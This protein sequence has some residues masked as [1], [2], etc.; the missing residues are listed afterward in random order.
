M[1]LK[2]A[3]IVQHQMFPE[4][5]QRFQPQFSRSGSDARCREGQFFL[6]AQ[7]RTPKM[8][9][10]P[11]NRGWTVAGGALGVPVGIGVL[12]N[13]FGIFTNAIGKEFGWDR[14]TTTLGLTIQHI[15]AAVSYVPM[16]FLMVRW[17]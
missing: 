16:G 3:A 8:F 1:S 5:G 2:R 11:L 4:G 13:S 17:G 14:S 9:N 12:G 15:C 10:Q 6:P 7:N